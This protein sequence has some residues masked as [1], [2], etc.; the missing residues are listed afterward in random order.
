MGHI[1]TG[2][3]LQHIDEHCVIVIVV[4]ILVYLKLI[5]PIPYKKKKGARLFCPV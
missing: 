3:K 2:G 4:L 5:N 1:K